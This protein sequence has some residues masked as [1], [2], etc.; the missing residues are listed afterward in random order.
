MGLSIDVGAVIN[1][2]LSEF[3]DFNI[4]I[5]RA[6]G[7]IFAAARLARRHAGDEDRRG[8]H[9]LVRNNLVQNLVQISDTPY[10]KSKN[11]AD[12]WLTV[13]ALSIAHTLPE[14]GGFVIVSS[15]RDYIPVVVKLRE[16]GKAVIGFGISGEVNP[17][18]VKSCDTFLYYSELRQAKGIHGQCLV[19]SDSEE[20]AL[21]R[22]S[23]VK[24]LIRATTTLNQQ[25]KEATGTRIVT[26][27]KEIC[28]DLDLKLARLNSFKQL[29]RVAEQEGYV[30]CGNAGMDFVVTLVQSSL[31][32]HVSQPHDICAVG[33]VAEPSNLEG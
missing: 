9:G 4:P 8:L 6:Y 1:E 22:A 30:R 10:L 23:Y 33:P 3:S 29:A 31:F 7:D 21:S 26:L 11:S 20:T 14:I 2:I 17:L 5:R 18:Y 16:L 15:D 25:G 27:M 32:N 19:H 24:L 13:D 12:M 28:P